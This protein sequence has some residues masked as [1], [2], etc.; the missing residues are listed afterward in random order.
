MPCVGFETTIPASELAKTVYTSDHSATVTC[1]PL[2]QIGGTKAPKQC[3]Y[4][5]S[6]SLN[7]FRGYLECQR[8]TH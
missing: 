2:L 1:P 8:G 5:V 4:Q 7:V 3:K 6:Q